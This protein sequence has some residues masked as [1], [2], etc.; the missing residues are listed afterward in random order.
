M[1]PEQRHTGEDLA[2]LKHRET[3]YC[4]ARE[5]HPPGW[6]QWMRNWQWKAEVTLNPE[7]KKQAA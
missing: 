3:L 1:T 7:R 6:S 2:L 5:R 4:E